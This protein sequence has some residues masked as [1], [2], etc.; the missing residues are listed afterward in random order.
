MSEEIVL[1]LKEIRDYMKELIVLVRANQIKD[2]L[3]AED[4]T[5]VTED[6]EPKIVGLGLADATVPKSVDMAKV[7]SYMSAKG[8][9]YTCNKCSGFISWELRP[10]RSYPLHVNQ[11]GKIVNDGNC[12]EYQP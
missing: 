8:I 11:E 2:T 6:V 5:Y 1:L 9:P 7:Y 10:E 4:K 3:K 12:P